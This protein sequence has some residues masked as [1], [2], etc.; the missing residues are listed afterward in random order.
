MGSTPAVSIKT[1]DTIGV[2]SFYFIGGEGE[3]TTSSVGSII[4]KGERR[5]Q[6]GLSMAEPRQELLGEAE[7][8]PAVRNFIIAASRREKLNRSR[9]YKARSAL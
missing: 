7:Q 4:A 6:A 8:P 2:Q 5:G 9:G 3:P 1:L